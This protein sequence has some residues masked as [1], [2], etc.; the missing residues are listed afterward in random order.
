MN[1]TDAIKLLALIKVA[2][3][4]AYRDMD[5]DSLNATVTM[6]ESTFP[7]TP[8]VIVEMA[9]DQHRRKSKFPPTVA[10]MFE[11]LKAI[12]YRST[13]DALTYASMGGSSRLVDRCRWVADQTSAFAR[14]GADSINYGSVT[15]KMLTGG[16]YKAL[17]GGSDG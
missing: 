3:P 4:T 13:G 11:E 7:S 15:E 1:R 2:Y 6:W 17:G 9:F 14:G 12:H 8:Y 10:E 5:E 16:G